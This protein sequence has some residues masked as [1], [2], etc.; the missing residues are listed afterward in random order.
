M[1]QS[2]EVVNAPNMNGG[3]SWLVFAGVELL[4]ELVDGMILSRDECSDEEREQA[5]NLL[6]GLQVG[7][8]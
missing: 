3:K 8:S 5:V 1:I 2:F 6:V 4:A 7:L